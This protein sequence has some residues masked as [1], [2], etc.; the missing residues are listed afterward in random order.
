MSYVPIQTVSE[1][2]KILCCQ[3]G[4]PIAPNPANMCVACIRTQVDI[5]ADIPKQVII[6]FCR[7]CERYLNP[8]NFWVVCSL[9]SRELMAL[10]LKRL[11]NLSKVKL[12][13][14][15]FVWTEPHSKRLKVK[16]T[17]QGEVMAGT[18]LQQTFVVE[19]VVNH[20]MC[21]DCRR[22]EAKDTWNA[23][24]Q[25]R[26]KTSQRKT[27][28]FLE[29]ILLKYNATKDCVGIKANQDKADGLD[30]YFGFEPYARK[31]VEFLQGV[32]PIRFNTSKKLISHDINSNTY[33]YKYVF[34]VEVVPV[35][36]DNIVCLPLRLAKSLGSIGQ[37][38]HVQKVTHLL[39]LIDPNTAQVAEI[40]ASTYFKS[41]FQ[42][43]VKPKQL[44]EYTV[45]NIEPIGDGERHR[46]S[47]Q[48]AISKR[49]VL[50]DCWVVKSSELGVNDDTIHCRTHLGHLL[51]P[52]D[53]VL[54]FDMKN[55]NVNDENLDKMAADKIPDVVLLKKVYAEKSV[56]NRKRKWKLKHMDNLG[57]ETGS[58]TSSGNNDYNDF[59]EDLEEDPDLR[60]NINVYK[61]ANKMKVQV[62][63]SDTEDCPQ[64]TLEEML[65]D[66]VIAP[67][68][69]GNMDE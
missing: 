34:S 1:E 11:K 54:G 50:A 32:V 63:D 31:M 43:L 48:G 40:N 62:E 55:T 24:V 58:V 2:Q 59:L 25:V 61:D 66:L 13:D 17:I 41:P 38:V 45:I 33:N 47:G 49:H 5:T 21:D 27:L 10:C 69:S 39:H 6:Y 23:S 18:I 37:I 35:C 29:Q 36:K 67:E 51:Q 15:N 52:G 14:A 65:D 19:Y 46:F 56:R 42:T 22:V 3:C 64:I 68:P 4:V 57:L 28:Y 44:T 53:A 30:F 26:Q 9:E 8:P 16:L 7:F 60:Q 20:Q 12:I